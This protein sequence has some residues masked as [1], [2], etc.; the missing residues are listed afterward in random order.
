[1]H[2]FQRKA[3][4]YTIGTIPL[5]KKAH[6]PGRDISRY[7]ANIS[8]SI[9]F[10]TFNRFQINKTVSDYNTICV[11]SPLN[12]LT[13]LKKLLADFQWK[14]SILRS[15]C[16]SKRCVLPTVHFYARNASSLCSVQL[17]SHGE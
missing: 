5:I 17:V 8:A 4:K 14:F 13:H 3:S 6:P 2:H 11:G 10:F 1:M 15:H 12:P 7:D 16:I 9:N